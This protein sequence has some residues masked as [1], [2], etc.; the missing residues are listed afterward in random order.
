MLE[1]EKAA[2]IYNAQDRAGDIQ[3]AFCGGG[4]R[5]DRGVRP[6]ASN[7]TMPRNGSAEKVDVL[8]SCW[9]TVINNTIVVLICC[10]P[11]NHKQTLMIL[12]YQI[13]KLLL[14]L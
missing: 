6:W 3:H 2:K 11:S 14:W 5:M 12:F 7:R 4:V 8:F 10:I 1:A 9:K 13:F